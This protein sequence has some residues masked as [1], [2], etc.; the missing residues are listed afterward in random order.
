MSLA[1]CR[2]EGEYIGARTDKPPSALN[3]LG[4]SGYDRLAIELNSMNAG[5]LGEDLGDVEFR[6]PPPQEY[7][8]DQ[9][10]L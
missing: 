6:A 3:L 10:N 7:V 8:L 9:F 2:L 1:T 5:D 4:Q